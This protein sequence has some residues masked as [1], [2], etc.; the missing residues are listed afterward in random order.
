MPSGCEFEGI[1]AAVIGKIIYQRWREQ[2][3]LKDAVVGWDISTW[4]KDRRCGGPKANLAQAV[5][6]GC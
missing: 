5:T 1:A 3:S 6:L 2:E 4:V